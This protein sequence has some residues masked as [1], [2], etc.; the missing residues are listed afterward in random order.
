MTFSAKTKIAFSVLSVSAW[1]SLFALFYFDKQDFG[2]TSEF[3]AGEVK[4]AFE[5]RFKIEKDEMIISSKRGKD[6]HSS[7]ILIIS[8][9]Q[10]LDGVTV[11]VA[12]GQKLLF[13][14]RFGDEYG[15]ASW[16]QESSCFEIGSKN[17]ETAFSLCPAKNE[18]KDNYEL[19]W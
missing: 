13:E 1:A 4:G 7:D 5:S 17:I 12:R 11:R 18:S 19:I 10:G 2:K 8:S 16:S 14:Q 15:V 3:N 9:K 6:D